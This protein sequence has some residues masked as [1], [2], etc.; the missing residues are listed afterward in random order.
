MSNT[1]K[2]R[3]REATSDETTSTDIAL[4]DEDL[5]WLA[6]HQTYFTDAL[7]RHV[8]KTHF[9]ATARA[10]WPNLRKAKVN[11]N[12]FIVAL[13]ACARF[14]LEPDGKQAA[15]V[16]YKGIATFQPMYQGF[17]DLM[18]RSGRVESV[19]FNWIREGDTWN[20]DAG[21]RPPADFTHRPN[22]L[23]AGDNEARPLLAYAFAWLK[24]GSRSQVIFLNRQQAEEIRNKHSKSY[25][26]AEREG[27]RDSTWHEHFDAMWAKSCVR[28]LAKVVPTS[29]ELIEL[30][31]ADEDAEQG[32]T[33]TIIRT[34]PSAE[35][36]EPDGDASGE[37]P[38]D[39]EVVGDD[40]PEGG[41][42]Q[43]QAAAWPRTAQPG[44]RDTDG[45]EAGE[46][47]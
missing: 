13:L 35:Q 2:D 41:E 12:S 25:A 47:A 9:I 3:V 17:I 23:R 11:P 36:A 19:H 32:V 40:Q 22:L 20:Y 21:A 29:P 31:R 34:L 15:I 27:T 44:S 6:S 28:R 24:G 38:V 45:S 16:P 1:L 39:A 7:P 33:P 26:K 14:G 42:Q 18:Y 46:S 30:L 10:L 5:A 43:A 37:P 4:R 8:D